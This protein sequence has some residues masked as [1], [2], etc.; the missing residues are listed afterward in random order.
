MKKTL[1]KKIIIVSGGNGL[2]GKS[3]I[4]DIKSHDGIPINLDLNHETS[5]DVLQIK[6]E[7]RNTSFI[8]L[9][10]KLREIFNCFND[11]TFCIYFK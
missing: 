10:L 9:R 5:L 6:C 3:I 2:L 4:S 1:S 8:K 7:Y 11:S